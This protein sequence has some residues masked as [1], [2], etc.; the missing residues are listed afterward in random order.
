MIMNDDLACSIL[1]LLSEE[2]VFPRNLLRYEIQDDGLCLLIT[3][4]IDRYM[5]SDVMSGLRQMAS[6]LRGLIP[7]RSGDFSWMVAL[8]DEG[9]VVESCFGGNSAIPDWDGEQFIE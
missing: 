9:A 8:T 5:D 2:S 7:G 1:D 3:V 4:P 6:T